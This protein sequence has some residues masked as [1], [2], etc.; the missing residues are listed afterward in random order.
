MPESFMQGAG[1]LLLDKPAGIT[2]HDALVVAKKKLN[3]NRIGHTGTLDP[4][5]TGLL[6]CVVGNATRLARFLDGER[7]TYSGKIK[8][9]LTTNTD[10][11][12]GQELGSSSIIPLS[13]HY[14]KELI[15]N[16][17]IFL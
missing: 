16:Y 11:V 10:D 1:L 17:L 13:L 3:L 2:S 4:M 12:T 8:L 5:A 15:N 6:L 9:G 7:K 14:F